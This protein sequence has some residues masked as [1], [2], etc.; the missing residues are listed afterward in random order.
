[1]NR[2]MCVLSVGIIAGSVLL[3][4]C[5]TN[6]GPETLPST[7]PSTEATIETEPTE[8][9]EPEVPEH[10]EPF[11]QAIITGSIVN[12]YGALSVNGN[13]INNSEGL[14]VVLK[15]MSSY[16]IQECGDFFTS[17]VV[18][19]LA[20]DWGCDV[21]RIAITGDANSEG[22]MKEPERYFD[23]ICKICDMCVAQGIYVIVDWNVLYGESSDENTDAAVDFFSRLSV[24]YSDTDNIIYEINNDP[25]K[26]ND[27]LGASDE[28]E[29]N[30]KPF[31]TRVIDAIR[32]NDSNNIIIVGTPKNGLGVNAASKSQLEYS[33]IAYGFRFFSGPH[34]EEQR[35]AVAEALGDGV[36][37]FVTQWALTNEYGVG[38][39]HLPESNKWIEFF[40]KN[41]IS[42]CN[43]AIGSTS[44]DDTN[45]L[46]LD[47]G[48][49]TDEQKNSGHWPLG[50][51]SESG[52]FAR[53]QFFMA[54][55]VEDVE[56]EQQS[57][58]E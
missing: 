19:T 36:C 20:E 53:E 48:R 43:Y 8:E 50:L 41:G 4:S 33:N 24:I 44:T 23:N 37:V 57:E 11:S 15:G 52:S 25:V 34:T 5:S 1:M 6:L 26:A 27:E 17:E 3:S 18:K 22:Y 58:E 56:E 14:K 45:A 2:F 29:N 21:L 7:T 54:D 35:N 39:I 31:A 13:D 30:I 28:W 47:D 32:E 49:Y 42:W 9:T 46:N 38:G 51:I 40:R 12:S 16:G 55:T 10:T